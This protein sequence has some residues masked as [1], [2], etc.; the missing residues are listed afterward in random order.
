MDERMT[1]KSFAE[2]P[3]PPAV[4]TAMH[5]VRMAGTA[6]AARTWP[7]DILQKEHRTFGT[8]ATSETDKQAESLIIEM[9]RGEFPHSVCVGEETANR[10]EPRTILSAA[11]V[12]FIDPRDGTTEASHELPFWCVSIGVME[13]GLLTG[14]AV[15]APDVRAGLTVVAAKGAGVYLSER[16]RSLLP[17]EEAVNVPETASPIVHLGVD[18]QR[19]NTF[20]RFVATLPKELKPRGISTSGALGLALVAAGRIDAIIQSPQM[21]WDFAAGMAMIME[22]G[23]VA[24]T[25]RIERQSIRSVDLYDPENFRTDK[26]KLMFVAGKASIV[27]DLFDLLVKSYGD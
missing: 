15:F 14:G 10:L 20:H 16:D 18:V 25:A 9:L 2:V 1:Q 19:L 26:Q 22:R 23:L 13:H 8:A 4:R 27:E 5:A 7:P 6:I 21:P 3:L 11:L 17:V 12:F 24:R